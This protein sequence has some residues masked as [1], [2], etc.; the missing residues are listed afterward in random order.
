MSQAVTVILAEYF[1]LEQS[2]AAPG[3][4]LLERLERVESLG[5]LIGELLERVTVIEA[6]LGG[7]VSE[8]LVNRIRKESLQPNYT[9]LLREA[10]RKR[11]EDRKQ[12]TSELPSESLEIRLGWD[13]IVKRLGASKSTIERKKSVFE[14]WSEEKDPDG[15]SWQMLKDGHKLVFAPSSLDSGLKS[16]LLEWLESTGLSE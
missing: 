12:F 7:S 14:E 11:K 4:L 8:P 2:A 10:A 5:G 15:I 6:K 3:G 1:G 9:P 16:K 13:V